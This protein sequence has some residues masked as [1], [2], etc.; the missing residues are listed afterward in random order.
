MVSLSNNHIFDAGEKGFFDTIRHLDKAG[1]Q[2]TGAGNSLPE[3]RAGRKVKVKDSSITILSYTQYCNSMYVSMAGEQAG[4]LP[5]DLEVMQEDVKQARESA[6]LVFVS[7][8]WGF[9]DQPTVHPRQIEIAHRLI[10][11]GADSIIG[12]HPHV[13]HGIELYRG[14]PILYSLG[15]FIFGHGKHSWADN[16]LADIVIEQKTIKGLLIYPIAGTGPELFQPERLRGP[17]AAALLQDLRM[18]SAVFRTGI[19]VKDDVGQVRIGP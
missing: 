4:I 1:I 11:A 19:A 10:D 9:E 15:N 6:D 13:P 12:H 17:R 8:H 2:W 14:R 16:Y 7:V 18:R 5:M 3:A